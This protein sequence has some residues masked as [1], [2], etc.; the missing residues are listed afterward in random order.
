M[1]TGLWNSIKRH[2]VVESPEDDAAI[3]QVAQ[4][5]VAKAT[6]PNVAVLV[7]QPVAPP[8]APTGDYILTDADQADVEA[9]AKMVADTL[10]A[11]LG[12]HSQLIASYESLKEFIADSETRWNA[13][14]KTVNVTREELRQ[15]TKQL[16]DMSV[17]NI[18]A[19][20]ERVNAAYAESL[21]ALDDE[22][23]ANGVTRNRT[24]SE[25]EKLQARIEQ[26]DQEIEAIDTEAGVLSS[27]RDN[28]A[29]KIRV[30]TDAIR[31]AASKVFASFNFPK[32]TK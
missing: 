11:Q 8:P 20:M 14:C 17:S 18:D 7:A 28:F 3:E 4:A 13:A 10:N 21:K 22:I 30:K 19:M 26:I 27:E 29:V 12:K 25:R 31:T 9:A 5:D 24:M 16:E 2:I 1:A 32:D 23:L 6:A 15:I